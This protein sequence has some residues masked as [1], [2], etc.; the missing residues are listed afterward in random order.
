MRVGGED[1]F[2][3]SMSYVMAIDRTLKVAPI[4]EIKVDTPY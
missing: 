2:T 1:D 3:G 4:S